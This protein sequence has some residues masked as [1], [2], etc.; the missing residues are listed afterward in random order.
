MIVWGGG[1][2]AAATL[3]VFSLNP[4][5]RIVFWIL[6]LLL[7]LLLWLSTLLLGPIALLWLAADPVELSMM[8]RP[9]NFI[10][11]NNFM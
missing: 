10:L 4:L 8:G 1:E 3:S 7:L 11:L 5:G 9:Q 2:G 6:L